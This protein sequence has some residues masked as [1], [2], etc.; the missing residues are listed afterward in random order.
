MRSTKPRLPKNQIGGLAPILLPNLSRGPP[1]TWSSSLLSM[2]AAYHVPFVPGAGVL[3]T[4]GARVPGL[5][6]P[7]ISGNEH[8]KPDRLR[9]VFPLLPPGRCPRPPSLLS[10]SGLRVRLPLAATT[11]R[12]CNH[13][14]SSVRAP[15]RN[16]CLRCFV[17]SRNVGYDQRHTLSARCGSQHHPLCKASPSPGGWTGRGSIA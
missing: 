16:H 17:K 1:D 2:A 8:R 6:T 15:S 5:S 4:S 11:G 10:R 14:A 3:S 12:P 13:P 9:P 7:C